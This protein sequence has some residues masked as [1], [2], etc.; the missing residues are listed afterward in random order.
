MSIVATKVY[1]R[2]QLIKNYLQ[3]CVG[4]MLHLTKLCCCG[5]TTEEIY[6]IYRVTAV[7]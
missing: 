3:V 6:H 2:V 7:V 4:P 5:C 1:F